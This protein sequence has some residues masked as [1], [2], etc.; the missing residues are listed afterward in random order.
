MANVFKQFIELFP[1]TKKFYGTLDSIVGD[2]ITVS[3]Q[4]GG[5]IKFHSAFY[6]RSFAT[7]NKVWLESRGGEWTL[8]QAPSFSATYNLEV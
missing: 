6:A 1:T 8:S 4:G 5:V 2:L 7:G 3:I